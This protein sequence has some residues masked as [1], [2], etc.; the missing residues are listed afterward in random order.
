MA[1]GQHSRSVAGATWVTQ[2]C[3][4]RTAS[5]TQGLQLKTTLTPTHHP[6]PPKHPQEAKHWEAAFQVYERGTSLFKYPHVG[7]IWAAY[8]KTFVARWVVVVCRLVCVFTKRVGLGVPTGAWSGRRKFLS[9]LFAPPHT[10]QSQQALG[11]PVPRLRQPSTTHA[12]T[13][14]HYP[15]FCLLFCCYFVEKQ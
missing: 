1:A 12:H 9:C 11:S 7:D 4:V 13:H 10:L 15:V 2:A 5:Q 8:L 14:T 6:P 3:A